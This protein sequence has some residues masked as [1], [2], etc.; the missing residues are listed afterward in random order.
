MV[1][2]SPNTILLVDGYNI[3][4][5]WP[6]LARQ[7]RQVDLEAARHSLVEAL[8]GYSA[9]HGCPTRVVFDAQYQSGMA[10][11]N[12]ITDELEVHFT[13]AGQTADTYIEWFCSQSRHT[14]NEFQ[15]I[16]VATSDRDH[17]LTVT[18]Y[19]AEWM[20][21]HQLIQ[22]IEM[23]LGKIRDRAQ[24]SKVNSRQ[25]LSSLIDPV[26]KQKLERLRF[27]LDP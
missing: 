25:F 7:Q 23:T 26:A 18:G 9:Y 24:R 8:T 19:G 21:A 22:G 11:R 10:T 15:R 27:G 3:I 1:A 16:I 20:S 6:R 5:S 4:G 14:I 17:R 12:Q 2:P 13:E